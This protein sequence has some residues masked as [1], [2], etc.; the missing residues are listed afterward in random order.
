[1]LVFLGSYLV[2]MF[3]FGMVCHELSHVLAA[4]IFGLPFSDLSLTHVLVVRSPLAWQ[5]MVV[6]LAG[7][8]GQAVSSLLFLVCLSR[9]EKRFQLEGLLKRTVSFGYRLGFLTIALQGFT[10]A[11]WEGIF[12]MSYLQVHNSLWRSG[13][14]FVACTLV[15][16]YL[17]Y[18]ESRRRLP[19]LE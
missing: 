15:A 18:R 7:G 2:G 19:S 11:A 16:F 3:F 10:F 5:N 4:V 14:S 9:L 12:L 6:G 8:I 17:L 1:M 13:S